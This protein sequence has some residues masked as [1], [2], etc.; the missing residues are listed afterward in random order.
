MLKERQRRRRSRYVWSG[1]A[2]GGAVVTTY[3]LTC[4]YRIDQSCLAGKRQPQEHQA[5]KG[6][7]NHGATA[8]YGLTYLRTRSKEL[9]KSS[10]LMGGQR[11]LRQ[12]ERVSSADWWW[13][14][15]MLEQS[16][17]DSIVLPGLEL[18]Q[19]HFTR[20]KIQQSKH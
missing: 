12:R 3:I 19:R 1:C 15:S 18:V 11:H 4:A 9:L 6:G 13:R 17:L 20:T 2:G 7:R 10:V 8:S 14:K 5:F 16:N